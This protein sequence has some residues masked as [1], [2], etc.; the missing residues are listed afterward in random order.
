[1]VGAAGRTPAI[2]GGRRLLSAR[3]RPLLVLPML[4]TE[5]DWLTEPV[6]LTE[7]DLLVA[8]DVIDRLVWRRPGPS[9]KER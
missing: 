4:G 9:P 3:S 5:P 8:G 6:R 1:M 7:P 2:V